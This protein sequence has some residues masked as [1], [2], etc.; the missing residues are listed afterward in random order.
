MPTRSSPS[1][2]R[3]SRAPG[4]PIHDKSFII[5]GKFGAAYQFRVFTGSHNLSGGALRKYDEIFVRLAPEM[6][7]EH[8]VYDHYI[9]HFDDAYSVGT[10]L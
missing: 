10:A 1:H 7:P 5:Y 6:G 3:P 8:P 4:S 9:T 2:C